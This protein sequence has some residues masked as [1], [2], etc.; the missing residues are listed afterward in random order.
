MGEVAK[1]EGLIVRAQKGIKAT[2]SEMKKVVWP[3]KTQL[4][5][6][7]GIVIAAIVIFGIILAVLD[8]A[9][10]QLAGLILSLG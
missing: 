6:N 3:T 2:K 7:T 8:I 9:F 4:I 10:T 5:N 1:K